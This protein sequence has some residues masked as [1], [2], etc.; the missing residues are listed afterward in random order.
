[1]N[2]ICNIKGHKSVSTKE[3]KEKH[4]MYDRS[5]A[6]ECEE[7]PSLIKVLGFCSNHP[8]VYEKVKNCFYCSEVRKGKMHVCTNKTWINSNCS[9][10]S[11][12]WL[13]KVRI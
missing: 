4:S 5:C 13:G 8:S 6:F 7:T 11:T 10:P 9:S 2:E 12:K 1:M 3:G